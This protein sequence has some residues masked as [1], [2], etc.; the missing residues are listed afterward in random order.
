MV[1]RARRGVGACIGA[2]V[3]LLALSAP[4]GAD[5]NVLPIAGGGQSNQNDVLATDAKF[6]DNSPSGIA[7]LHSGNF[8]YRDYA[9]VDSGDCKI[10]KIASASDSTS[11]VGTISTV[12]G[13]GCSTSGG[14]YAY[15]VPGTL[16]TLGYASD[17]AATTRNSLMIVDSGAQ[18]VDEWTSSTG[19]LS[20][21]AGND[22]NL[23]ATPQCD[24]NPANDPQFP[25]DGRDAL[26]AG[27][28]DIER[29]ASNQS[30]PDRILL[31]DSGKR[32]SSG[33]VV[34]PGRVYEVYVDPNPPNHLIVKTVAGG[35]DQSLGAPAALAVCFNHPL[36][37]TYTGIANDSEFLVT[38]V[39]RHQ[40]FRFDTSDNTVA[41]VVAGTGQIGNSGNGG[42]ATAATFDQPSDVEMTA[43]GGYFIADTYNC[44]IK[45]VTDL[46]PQANIYDIAGTCGSASSPDTT[47]KTAFQANLYPLSIALGPGGLYIADQV[48]K[49]VQLIDRTSIT[50]YP[51]A[52]SN[53]I[54]ANF[55]FESLEFGGTFTCSWDSQ[56]LPCSSPPSSFAE[57]NHTFTVAATTAGLQADPTPGIWSWTVDVTPPQGLALV[58]P[59]DGATGLPPSPTFT[60]KPADGGPSGITRYE[61]SIDG[62][63]DHD[64]KPADC[65]SDACTATPAAPLSGA[66]HTWKVRAVDGA[67]NT[68]DTGERTFTLA[69]LI[70]DFT[71]APNPV[72][73]GRSVTFDASPSVD[74]I[75]TITRYEWDLDGDGTFETDGGTSPTTTKTY[76]TPGTV[77]VGL[78]VTDSGGATA[79]KTAALT[80]T[81]AQIAG[82]LGVTINDR[83][84]YTNKPDVTLT[85]TA[86]TAVT[87]L[88]VSNDGG[89]IDP[90]VFKP[91]KQIDWKLDSS[92][93][94][95]LPKTVYV[96]FVSGLITSPNYTD[97]IILDER[98]P[99]VDQASVA[100]AAPAA[101]GAATAAALKKWRVKV[102][103]HDTN[104]GVGFVQVTSNKRKP[105]KLIRYKKRLT[106]KSAKRPKFLRARDRAGNFSRWKKLR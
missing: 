47:T 74:P 56:T 61:L 81:A 92:G 30:N 46:T 36:G 5:P 97:D 26:G 6:K 64:V 13:T 100:P 27:F 40:V 94:E 59:A 77:N 53:T 66:Q 88:L 86:P 24:P 78:R 96:R 68:S 2:F 29:V 101:S 11:D 62:A 103:A 43:D 23:S 102:K 98:A 4:V 54:N 76:T 16:Y 48:T 49:Q 69:P 7:V 67:G 35:C 3:L 87:Q 91:A 20:T 70:A 80:V 95:R 71:I 63:K 105:G 52:F 82:Q 75:G 15:A 106:V 93:P 58:S 33:N 41:N 10:R 83:A 21:Y 19:L 55:V 39:G 89:F 65:T 57:G 12:V 50:K 38:D 34:F 79:T 25:T 37:V 31:V 73:A 14:A 42:P 60:W 17:V 99:V 72:L 28:C 84:Q 32:D 44:L 85:I 8:F 90:R 22:G 45:K 1:P 9:V 18:A 51:P 104:S